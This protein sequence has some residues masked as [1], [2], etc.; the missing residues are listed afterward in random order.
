VFR[1]SHEAD[2]CLLKLNMLF[3]VMGMPWK[4]PNRMTLTNLSRSTFHLFHDAAILTSEAEHYILRN[5]AMRN[6]KLI[7]DWSVSDKRLHG[8]AF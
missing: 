5:L 7:D 4:N 3:F 2:E 6:P 1:L 8:L